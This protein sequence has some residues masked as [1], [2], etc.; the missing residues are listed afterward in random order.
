[1]KFPAPVY[2]VATLISAVLDDPDLPIDK[3]KVAIAGYSAGGNLALAA[4]QLDNLHQRIK[5]VVAYYPVT[6]TGRTMEK[7]LQTATD[8]PGRKDMLRDL[9]PMFHWAYFDKDTRLDD[10]LLAPIRAD[11]DKLPEKLYL[12]GCE[13]DLLCTEAEETAEL[14]ATAEQKAGRGEKIAMEGGSRVGWTCGNV[15]WEK[16]LG[17]EHGFNHRAMQERGEVKELW[18]RRAREMHDNVVE[19]LFREVY[20]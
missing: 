5:G 20:N 2:D 8:P 1:V 17:L 14:Y 7:R 19:W 18:Q 12:I 4:P 9:S 16:L 15:T 13:W 6:D 3:S 10:P 11:R